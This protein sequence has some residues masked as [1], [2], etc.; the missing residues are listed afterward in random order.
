M[1]K[2]KKSK[3]LDELDW[4]F[5]FSLFERHHRELTKIIYVLREILDELDEDEID[6]EEK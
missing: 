6:E 1:T 4:A 5:T 2:E 3:L